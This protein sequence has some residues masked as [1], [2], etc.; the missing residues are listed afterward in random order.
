MPDKPYDIENDIV[1][2]TTA[3]GKELKVNIF[4]PK[5]AIKATILYAHGGGFMKGNRKDVTAKR[6]AEKLCPEGVMVASFDYRLKANIS[7]FPLENQPAIIAAQARTARVGMPINPYFCGPRFYAA[8]EDLSDAVFFLRDIDGP[9]ASKTGPLLALGVSAGGIAALSLAFRPRGVWEE[10]SQPDAV[11]GLAAAM[12]Q[13]WRLA[14][15]GLPSLLFHGRTDRIISPTNTRFI[16]RRVAT[17]AAPLEVIVT[18][19]RGHNTQIDLFIDGN[20]PDGN[21]WL[22]KARRMMRLGSD[23]KE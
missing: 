7:A 3:E 23:H 11:I 21:P 14:S 16:T 15:D 6:L 12:V 5:K 10:L 8:L 19:T 13:P 4:R 18:D 20:D 1:Y 22:N 2:K 17:S 9:A